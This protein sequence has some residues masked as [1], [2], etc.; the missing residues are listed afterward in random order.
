MIV[1][2]LAAVFSFTPGYSLHCFLCLV[3]MSGLSLYGFRLRFVIVLLLFSICADTRASHPPLFDR[4]M[5]YVM[6]CVCGC[7]LAGIAGSNPAGGV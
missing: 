6:S 5:Q 3:L 2:M 1:E 7:S 4:R